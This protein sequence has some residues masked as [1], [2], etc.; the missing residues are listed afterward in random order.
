MRN[1]REVLA[2]FWGGFYNR[3]ALLP[4]PTPIP[5]FQNGYVFFR[6]AQGRPLPEP[7]YPYITYEIA[8][9]AMSDFVIL[10]A[11]IYD[12]N[13]NNPGFMGLVDDVLDQA[14]ERVPE[15]GLMLDVGNRGMLVLR[16]STPF[17]DYLD[18][19]DQFISRGIIR[20]AVEG[21]LY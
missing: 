8:L 19:P 7:V 5:A 9:P 14:T 6:D 1:V 16:R 21:Y 20:Y 2:G 12:R 17:I 3:S 11:N 4:A 10:T 18:D 15:S 13:A